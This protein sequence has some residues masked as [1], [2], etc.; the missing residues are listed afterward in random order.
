MVTRK[1]L[2]L[3]AKMSTSLVGH[4]RRNKA[5]LW[6]ATVSFQIK[7]LVLLMDRAKALMIGQSIAKLMTIAYRQGLK[8][9]QKRR[10]LRLN[11]P[12]GSLPLLTKTSNTSS[13]LNRKK[14]LP[15]IPHLANQTNRAPQT[16]PKRISRGRA[17][18][19]SSKPK[20]P[21]LLR[22]TQ[23]LPSRC[24]MASC[25]PSS[26]PPSSRPHHTVVGSSNSSSSHT[27]PRVRAREATTAAP[28][29]TPARCSSSSSS[30]NRTRATARR[31]R[32]RRRRKA[33]RRRPAASWRCPWACTL[34]T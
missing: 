1:L 30:S 18:A 23:R 19:S 8:I 6:G 16:P 11:T 26:H 32:R 25:P 34:S 10:P 24:R 5:L 31:R 27:H 29:G 12:G 17:R 4:R 22:S 33:N 21:L 15:F 13:N 28:R 2:R 9:P 7:P 14:H 3:E 20:R